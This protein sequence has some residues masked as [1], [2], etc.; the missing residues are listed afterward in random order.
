[1]GARDPVE[2]TLLRRF[3][4]ALAATWE[5]VAA[6]GGRVQRCAAHALADSA[7]V[8]GMRIRDVRDGAVLREADG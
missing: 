4:F 3:V 6:M 2:D 7:A 5:P 1:V 8:P